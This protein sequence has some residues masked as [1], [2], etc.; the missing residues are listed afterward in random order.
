MK[1]FCLLLCASLVSIFS[2][3]SRMQ[4]VS[5]KWKQV[6]IKSFGK[7][8]QAVNASEKVMILDRN[9]SYEETLYGQM[10]IKGHWKFNQDSTR[11]AFEV[12]EYNG[13]KVPGGYLDKM[14]PTDSIMRLTK[15][16]LIYASLAYHG[17]KKVYGHTDWYFVREK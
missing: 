10:K 12:F 15:D 16:T 9:G 3:D 17:P 8:Y 14:L 7:K 11:L 1:F 5:H 2:Q 13:V 6:G 4:L